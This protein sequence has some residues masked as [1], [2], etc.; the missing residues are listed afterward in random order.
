MPGW[1]ASDTLKK[2]DRNT[3]PGRTLKLPHN[4]PTCARSPFTLLSACS[5]S[6]VSHERRRNKLS[7]AT[8]LAHCYTGQDQKEACVR[9]GMRRL[10]EHGDPEEDRNNRDAI[11]DE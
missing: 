7:A 2:Q 11:I 8:N 4:L 6:P 1:W 5:G 10:S 9:V 3:G